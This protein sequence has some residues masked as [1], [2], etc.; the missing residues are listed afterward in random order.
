MTSQI[1]YGAPNRLAI[2]RIGQSLYPLN[3]AWITGKSIRSGPS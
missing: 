3:A 1:V 2:T